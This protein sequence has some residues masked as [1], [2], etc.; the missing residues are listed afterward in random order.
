MDIK[1]D[2]LTG[3]Q[4]AALIAEH[5]HGMTLHSPPESIHALN[6]EGLKQP[7]VTFWSAWEEEELLGCGALKQLDEQHGELK[8]MRTATAHLRKG[9]ARR[10]LEHIITEAKQ[11][12]YK[13]LSLETG[14]M[15]AFSPARTLYASV[16]FQDCGPFA[17]YEEDPYSI[18]MTMEL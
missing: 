5:L 9:V 10:V 13:R 4:I 7:D 16:G 17:D 3:S 12:G 1:Q 14:S 8:S 2:D 18:F 11:R 15:E 6:L